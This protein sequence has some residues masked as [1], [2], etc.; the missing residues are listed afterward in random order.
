MPNGPTTLDENEIPLHTAVAELQRDH[1]QV[2][3]ALERHSQRLLAL[4]TARDEPEDRQS[5]VHVHIA[6]APHPP[7]GL[8]SI[9]PAIKRNRE[10]I[11]FSGLGALVVWALQEL[12]RY[13]TP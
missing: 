8:R 2:V 3:I 11:A 6:P 12:V 10:P 1:L 9:A 4:E 5:N 7:H 13:W